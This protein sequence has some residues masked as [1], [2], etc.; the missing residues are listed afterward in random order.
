MAAETWYRIDKSTGA[1][2]ASSG[3]NVRRAAKASFN[4]PAEVL[5]TGRFQTHFAIYARED[6]LT[7]SERL[8][9]T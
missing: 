6:M 7:D 9:M 2:C 8:Q 5:K 4:L 1:I 3:G